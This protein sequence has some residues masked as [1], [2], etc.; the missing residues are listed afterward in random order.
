MQRR[1]LLRSCRGEGGKEPLAC[2][3][4]YACCFFL[5]YALLFISS[6]VVGV[7]CVAHGTVKN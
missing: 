7:V 4:D 3:F 6:P 5:N 2:D 1:F